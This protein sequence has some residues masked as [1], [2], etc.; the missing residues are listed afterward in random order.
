M[1]RREFLAKAGLVAT[2]AGVTIS[3]GACSSDGDNGTNPPPEG[4]VEGVIG[5]NHGHTGAVVTEAQLQA[6]EAVRLT[7][8]TVTITGFPPHNHT[9]DLTAQQVMDI[10]AGTQVVVESSQVQHSHSVTFN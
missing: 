7:L 3:V 10:G 8:S 9:V 1:D 2:W 6:G 4:D 5:S